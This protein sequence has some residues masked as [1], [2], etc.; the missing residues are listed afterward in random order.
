MTKVSHIPPELGALSE[1][2]ELR[3]DN[4]KLTGTIPAELGKL[5]ALKTLDL[6]H[7][8]LSGPIPKELGALRRLGALLLH[9]NN[10]TGSIPKELGDLTKLRQLELHWNRLTGSIP[11]EVGELAALQFLDLSHNQLTG[12]IPPELGKLTALVNL[13]L[14]HNQLSG[15][16][17]KELG[18]LRQLGMLWISDNQ[19]SGLWHTL[20]QDQIGSMAARRGTLPVDLARLLDML[21]G[22]SSW[23]VGRN[24][25]EHPPE[26]IVGGGLQVVRG[27][28]EAMFMG[29]TTAVTRPL[30]V[31]IVGKE[32][33]GKTRYEGHLKFCPFSS[34]YM[35]SLDFAELFS[36]LFPHR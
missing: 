19:L 35:C 17:P 30:K 31:V 5:E 7:N 24:P 14:W 36:S 26:A 6:E 10:L 28:Y 33:V 13:R 25:W 8:K 16:I 27:Y 34:F 15:T 32:T 29:G 3:L 20:G 18:A 1:L 12:P 2:Q 22:L 11:P 21:D 23:K 9:R 4:N